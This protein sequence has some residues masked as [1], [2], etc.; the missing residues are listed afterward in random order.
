M[1][2]VVVR[3]LSKGDKFDD[4]IHEVLHSIRRH[5]FVRHDVG[6]RI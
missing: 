5:E 2:R 4:M 6:Y 1:N 3:Y